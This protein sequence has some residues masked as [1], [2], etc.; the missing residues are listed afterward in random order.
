[1]RTL[2]GL[3]Y[4]FNGLGEYTLVL[5]EDPEKGEQIFELQGRTQRVYDPKTE[6]PTDATSYSGF[7]ALD[8]VSGSMVGIQRSYNM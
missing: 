7:A 4:T 5:I 3:D 2:D 1:M 8:F 6:K